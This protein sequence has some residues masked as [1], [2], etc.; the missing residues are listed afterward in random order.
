MKDFTKMIAILHC[1]QVYLPAN[2]L[3]MIAIRAKLETNDEIMNEALRMKPL[4]MITV[5]VPSFPVSNGTNGP[6][7][8]VEKLVDL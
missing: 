6:R 7:K 1:I 5:L 4:A 3:K 2:R 8:E